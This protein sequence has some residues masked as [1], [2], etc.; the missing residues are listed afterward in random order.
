V[1]RGAD[2]DGRFWPF[3]IR[4]NVACHFFLARVVLCQSFDG[5][6]DDSASTL[7]RVLPDS[8]DPSE[9]L[10]IDAERDLGPSRQGMKMSYLP[11]SVKHA[12]AAFSAPRT[13][14]CLRRSGRSCPVCMF[15]ND[16][17]STARASCSASHDVGT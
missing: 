11:K 14:V 6:S 10:G 7:A 3:T 12:L 2:L 4:G 5:P 15:A 9:E 13:L 17:L 16:A 1:S 8:L